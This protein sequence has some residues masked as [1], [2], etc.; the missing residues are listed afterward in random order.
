MIK[1]VVNASLSK[2]L[3]WRYSRLQQVVSNPSET[4]RILLLKLLQNA[5]STEIGKKYKFH[6]IKSY[7]DFQSQVPVVQYEDLKPMIERMMYGEK[8]VLWPGRVKWFSKSSGTTSDR[9]KFIPVSRDNLFKNHIKGSW[10]TLSILY[11][12]VPDLG[13][14]KAKSLIMGGSISR[15]SPNPSTKFGDI[16]AIMIHHMP[17]IGRPFYTPD[18]DTAILPDWEEKIE[19]TAKRILQEDIVM[20]GGVPTWNVVLFKRVLEM[21]GAANLLE[22]W[23]MLRVYVHGG[24]GFEPYKHY[25]KELIPREDFLYMEVYNASE[26]YFAISGKPGDDDLL[27]LPDNGIFY[28]FIPLSDFQKGDMNA[29][30]LEEVE[31]GANYVLLVSSNAGLWR[32]IIGDTVRFTSLR[33]YKIQITG[34]TQ[35]FV[36]AFGEEVMV[37]NTDKALATTCAAHNTIVKDYTVA[38]LYIATNSKGGHEWVIEFEKEPNDL[39]IFAAD[40]DKALQAV[41]SDY[42]AKRTLDLALSPLRIIPAP[43]GTFEDWL[44][45]K[46]KLGGQ[47]KVP[48]LSNNR[49]VL[50]EILEFAQLLR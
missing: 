49:K 2:Y 31:A 50:E 43:A 44:K 29:L 11:N 33:P 41:N 17:G 6:R 3:R 32:Y 9:S 19:R 47:T 27:L 5:Q 8:D 13:I 16:S 25:F 15:F 20:F 48:R 34:R 36:N 21:T 7:S 35:Q 24:V 23:P 12:N 30:S 18:F 40:L 26:G 14:F 37:S 45:S 22:I 10:D 42:E 39:S 4:Q 28:E 1:A 46:G 38:P